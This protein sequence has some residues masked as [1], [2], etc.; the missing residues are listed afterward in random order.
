MGGMKTHLL[1]PLL[2]GTLLIATSAPGDTA[3]PGAKPLRDSSDKANPDAEKV[4]DSNRRAN[5]DTRELRDSIPRRANP[6]TAKVR[7]GEEKANPDAEKVEDTDPNANPDAADVRDTGERANPD[8]V[9]LEDENPTRANPDAR[10]VRDTNRRANP[11]SEVLRDNSP[12]RANDGSEV[13]EERETREARRRAAEA[14]PEVDEAVAEEAESGVRKAIEEVERE[15]GE[16]KLEIKDEEQAREVIREMLGSEG[17]LSRAERARDERRG[18]RRDFDR[19]DAE[20]G[21]DQQDAVT[22]LSRRLM[23]E[24]DLG[25]APQFFRRPDIA[26]REGS[27]FAGRDVI[28]REP[29]YYHEGRRYLPYSSRSEI[30]AILLAS[31]ALDRIRIQPMREVA[32]VF[33][34]FTGYETTLPAEYRREESQVISYPVNADTMIS[35]NDI[36]FRQGSTAFADQHSYEMM[37]TLA[38]TMKRSQLR[39]DT[40]VIE[41]H[42]SAEGSFDDNLALSQRRA[43]AIVRD[44]VR[45]GIDPTRLV[46][47]GYGETEAEHPA[48][49]PESLRQLDRRVVVV[50]LNE[51]AVAGR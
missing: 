33:R 30:P 35:S 50:K 36:L 15:I 31:A 20:L 48:D 29:R 23:G 13:L 18:I 11:D 19:R 44:L 43:E 26:V 40:F 1:F 3:N 25:D 27:R 5:P 21:R 2:G 41:G 34:E 14:L 28:L 17:R 8:A 47:I 38:E 22:F 10:R 45:A 46:P 12:R 49:A 32:P 39:D 42:A 24:A 37:L 51:E 7:D 6:D 9:E 16:R 4:Q